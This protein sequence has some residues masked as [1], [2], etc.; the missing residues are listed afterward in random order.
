MWRTV[1]SIDV[2]HKVK[3]LKHTILTKKSNRLKDYTGVAYFRAQEN[4][5]HIISM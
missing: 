4:L 2:E 3:P 5:K 1:G